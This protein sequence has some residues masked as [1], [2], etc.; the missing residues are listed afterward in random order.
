[1][2]S[3]RR[4]PGRSRQSGFTLI[5]ILTVL[6]LVG[7]VS[8]ILFE[9]LGQVFS[10]R[11]RLGPYLDGVAASRMTLSWFRESTAALIS[12]I[13]DGQ[14]RF[15]GD[16]RGFSGLSLMPLDAE[17]G[18]PTM[19]AWRLD[20]DQADRR[21]TLQYRGVRPQWLS[22]AEWR[23]RTGAFSFNDGSGWVSA[24]P[25]ADIRPGTRQIPR[26]IR[27]DVG[28]GDAAWSIVVGA[29]EDESRPQLRDPLDAFRSPRQ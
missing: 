26:Q 29:I 9:A 24:W 6:I 5:E 15:R 2:S 17:P 10:V 28:Q 25:P 12:D 19:I 13:G 7:L 3:A 8:G 20:Y 11:Q 27:V 23:D 18:T 16:A 14:S 21:T 4:P 1:M 22:V